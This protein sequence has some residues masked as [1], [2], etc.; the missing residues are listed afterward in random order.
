MKL[1][2]ALFVTFNCL[3]VAANNDVPGWQSEFGK[4][5]SFIEN[6]GQFDKRLK[7]NSPILYAHD[8][9]DQN[10]F[11]TKEGVVFELSHKEQRGRTDAETETRKTRKANGFEN[12]EEWQKFQAADFRNRVVEIRDELRTIWLGSNPDVQ[13]IAEEKDNFYHSYNFFNSANKLININEIASYKKIIYKNLY[14]NIDVVYEFHPEI[15]I[16][17]SVVLHPGADPS[18]VQLKYSKDIQLLAD[19]TIKTKTSLGDIIDHAPVTF[20]EGNEG[21]VIHSKYRVQNNTI[22]F[23]LSNYDNSRTVVIDPWTQTPNFNTNWKCVWE[24]ERDGAGN[25]YLIG[26]VMPLQLLKYNAAGALQ[27]TYNTPYDT[28]MWLGTF[29]TDLAGNSYVSNGSEAKI[30]KISTAGGLLWDNPNPGG[31]FLLTE[32]WNITFN[33]DQTRLV[34]G[35]TGG[36]LTPTPFIYEMDMNS[37]NVSSSAQVHI[38]GSFFGSEVRSITPCNNGRYYFLTHD[39]LGYIH[40]NLSACGGGSGSGS[41]NS[42]VVDNGSL[43]SYKCEN[44][45]YN[46][47]GIMALRYFNN[48]IYLNRGNQL[49]KRDFFTGNVI[50]TV[51]IPG[52]VYNT[53]AFPSTSSNVGNSGIDI[54]ICGNIYVGSTNG[55]YVFDQNLT[56]LNSFATSFN[57]YDVHVSTGG[58]VI[59]CGSTGT[60]ATASRT[61]Y[62][63]SF[64]AGACAPTAI[65]CCDVAL[66]PVDDLCIDDDPVSIIPIGTPGGTWSGTGVNASGVFDP[67]VAGI[68][69]H[70]VTYTLACGFETI[71]IV[72]EECP[73]LEICIDENGDLVASGGDGNYNWATGVVSPV[74]YPINTE[75]E[76]IDC[77]TTTPQYVPIFGFYDGCSSNNCNTTDTTWTPAGTGNTFTPTTYP[78]LVVDGNG[79]YIILENATGLADCEPTVACPTITVTIQNQ[80]NILCFG[81]FSGSATVD[82]SG[83]NG[84]YNYVW[85]PGNLNGSSQSNLS[86]QTYTVNV[87]DSDGCPGVVQVNITQPTP[88]SATTS[89]TEACGGNDGSATINVSGGTGSYTYDWNPN[90]GNTATVTDLSVGDYEVTVTDD[91]GCTMIE[92]I[93]VT[94]DLVPC[95]TITVSITNQSDVLCFGGNTGT[96]TVSASGGNGPYT[97]SWSP[98]GLNGATQNSLSALTY[99]VNVI[100]DDGCPGTVQVTINQPTQL[101]ATTSSVEASCG[102]SDGSATVNASGGTG[103]YTYTWTPNVGS[104]ATVNNIPAGSYQVIV[105]DANNCQIQETIIVN[106]QNAPSVSILSTTDESC[107]GAA[108]GEATVEASGG[109]GNYTYSW[110]PSGGNAATASNLPSGNYTV[111]VTDDAGCET[112]IVVTINSASTIIV[113]ASITDEDCGML[114]GELITSVSG[115]SGNYSYLW[116]NGETTS[117]ISGLQ[118]GEYTVVVTDDAGCSASEIFTVGVIGTLDVTVTPISATIEAGESIQLEASGGFTYSWSPTT[119]LSCTDCPDPI[120]SPV[121]S[122]TYT[123][124][125]VD[126]NGCAGEA[127]V[128]IF[129]QALCG[130]LF[131]PTIFSPNSDGLNDKHCIL[132]GCITEFELIIYNRWGE[133]VFVSRDQAN[134]WDGFFRGEKVQSGVYVYKINVTLVDGTQITDSGNINVVR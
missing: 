33:C 47:S 51:N 102:E 119:G 46:N 23:Q 73:E 32:F 127:T 86:A 72:V 40:N 12:H 117:S 79:T 54:D 103:S 83:G 106:N 22:S 110:S 55:V 48:F 93:S 20:Y 101:S 35:G 130:E 42:F 100:D 64:S 107:V 77:P 81:D 19:G 132:G 76:C 112:S 113:D 9:G 115:G 59:A 57:V 126:E 16:K 123:V 69:S 43:M 129:V 50:A 85:T 39:S 5:R 26:G 66:C 34:I 25:V 99:T 6:K 74:S 14:P 1:L 67:A 97:Y 31:L 68:G 53:V 120:A 111:T 7:T 121:N 105:S 11:F 13:I 38:P 15:G 27:W 118:T 87:T 88:L 56:Q 75:Q 61:G 21:D 37:G 2:F 82:A 28:T 125:A 18:V 109:S 63:Q 124:T 96:A 30:Q 49:Q 4:T 128:Y 78:L 10:Y 44:Y 80:T 95:P 17:Y 84:P 62:I 29:A 52:G 41:S 70:D 24:C 94:C 45:R 71:T 92:T 58:D 104:T 91:N 98:G 122:T 116:S 8:G 90:V 3:M 133:R 134:C 60:S 36:S 114:N 89:S 65:E 131:I 108:D